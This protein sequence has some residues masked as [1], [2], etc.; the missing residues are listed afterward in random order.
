MAS[1]EH[2][3]QT[4]ERAYERKGVD[5]ANWDGA[6]ERDAEQASDE[7]EQERCLPL[8]CPLGQ[9]IAEG[10]CKQYGWAIV[11]CRSRR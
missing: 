8:R 1:R 10:H 5:D 4:E 3:A 9:I 11:S 2:C 7:R 6:C